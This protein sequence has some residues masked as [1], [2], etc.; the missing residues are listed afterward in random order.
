MTLKVGRC[1]GFAFLVVAPLHALAAEPPA[2]APTA[3]AAYTPAP[4]VP[5]WIVTV[6]GELRVIPA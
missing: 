5:D 1:A 4:A 2:A 6:G 3:P